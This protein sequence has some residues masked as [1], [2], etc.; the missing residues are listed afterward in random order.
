MQ[1]KQNYGWLD[2]S[3]LI[4][5]ILVIAIHT[6]PL[7][8]CSAEAD[9]FLTRISARI[10]VPLFLMITGQ[11]VVS[12]FISS[13]KNN[14]ALPFSF[15]K[16]TGLL[17]GAA[18]LL[19][20]PLG[21]YAGHYHDLSVYGVIRMLLFDGT[22]YHL[23]YFPACIIGVLLL[24]LLSRC[25]KPR[26]LLIVS[27]I[28]YL[29]GLMGDS[30]Y[31]LTLQLPFVNT[32]YEGLFHVFSYTR[33][34]IFF[35]PFFLML[36]AVLPAE[37]AAVNTS[38][39]LAV[40]C[41]RRQLL[42]NSI[43]LALSFLAMTGEAFTLRHFS[44]QRHDSM[45]V[46]L[47]PTMFFLYRMLQGLHGKPSPF[48]RRVS[49]WIYV[50]H[51]A[52]I[53]VVRAA[54]RVT[55]T[56][57]LLVDNSLV[58]Y[59]AVTALTVPAAVLMTLLLKHRKAAKVSA[60]PSPCG[61][62]FITLDRK[63]LAENVLFL[64]SRL[65]EDCKLMPAVKAE[66]YGHG[67]VLISRELNRLGVQAFCVACVSEGITLRKHGIKGE[68]LV[69]GYTHPEDFPK[70]CRYHLTQTVIDY[71]YAVLLNQSGRKIHV[72]IGV[73]T[74]MH[75]LG[76]R[77]ENVEQICSVYKMPN[78]VIDGIYTHLSSDDTDSPADRA[79]TE[80][81]AMS[82]YQL[83]DELERRGCHCGAFHLQASYG[84][85]NY[86]EFSG[87]YARAGIALYGVLSTGEDTAAWAK[88]LR[89]VLSLNARVASVRELY[90]G[91]SAGYGMGFTAKKDM[92][93][94]ALSIGYADGLPR[95]LSDGN[96]SV[97]IRGHRA[98]I[99][100]R[101]CMDQTIVDVS[102]IPGIA[103]GDT[104][105]LI[106]SSGSETI[107]AADLAEEAGTITNEILSRLGSR[108]ERIMI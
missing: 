57:S 26:G 80:D 59:L 75:R 39:A 28:L 23:W 42:K 19:Y 12:G 90:E 5:A 86:P 2:R 7:S 33:N 62:A 27:G 14:A 36:G 99:I 68:I 9:F 38:Q 65:P 73:D 81:Q 63:A 21:I 50:L 72:H 85:L 1:S 98:P 30:Y 40:S 94:A 105:V 51:P 47:I 37:E 76:E 13:G 29:F 22:F 58:H 54:A 15:L 70:L 41:R 53:I 82:F 18:I 10:A 61:R 44:L 83:L 101:I 24:C 91:E 87:D 100:G 103:S 46:A 17:Y 55:H 52:V 60:L 71:P 32:M 74:G 79:F 48:C 107:T 34:G 64:R 89:P 69:L 20:F 66:A 6:S 104:A 78:L 93:I 96:G 43:G 25:L 95:A 3:R 4:A 49:A 8:T 31:G 108:L 97:L 35:A 67:A 16:K 102:G 88:Y 77:C 45:Y 84:I 56:T 106:G 11:F 92:K